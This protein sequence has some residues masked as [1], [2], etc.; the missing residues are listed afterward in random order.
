MARTV[1]IHQKIQALPQSKIKF[2]HKYRL[3][4]AMIQSITSGAHFPYHKYLRSL[5]QIKWG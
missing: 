5:I 2:W 4:F 1:Y 3:R